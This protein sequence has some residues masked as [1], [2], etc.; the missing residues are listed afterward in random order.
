MEVEGGGH[1]SCY[2]WAIPI[3][4]NKKEWELSLQWV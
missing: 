3:K 2:R 1:C 4:R